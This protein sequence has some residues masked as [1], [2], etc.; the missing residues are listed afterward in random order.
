M[1]EQGWVT[2][3]FT[4]RYTALVRNTHQEPWLQG[5]AGREESALQ[6]TAHQLGRDPSWALSCFLC[7]NLPTL[8]A[9]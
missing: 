2:Y 4:H 7:W 9:P 6:P 3:G 1:K 8:G 5:R